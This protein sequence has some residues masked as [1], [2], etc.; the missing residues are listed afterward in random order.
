MS[1]TETPPTIV[2]KDQY[3]PIP[4]T[5]LFLATYYGGRTRSG[6]ECYKISKGGFTTNI[7]TAMLS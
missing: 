5:T 7:K 1:G 2:A 4:R 6:L 3:A